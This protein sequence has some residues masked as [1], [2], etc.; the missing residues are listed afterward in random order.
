[1]KSGTRVRRLSLMGKEDQES[2][3]KLDLSHDRS[4]VAFGHSVEYLPSLV[5]S[6]ALRV[7]DVLDWEIIMSKI[8][9]GFYS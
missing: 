7:L 4:L 1:M 3:D 6:T 2:V 9:E 5:K 8:S